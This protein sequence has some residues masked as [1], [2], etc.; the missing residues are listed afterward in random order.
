M[1]ELLADQYPEGA[2]LTIMNTFYQYP[3]RDANGNRLDDFIVIVYKD[4]ITGE[5]KY[6]IISKP[7]Y[8]FYKVKDGVPFDDTYN[9]FFIEKDKVDEVTVPYRMI[10][11]EI[12]KLTGNLDFYNENIQEMNK[13]ENKKL[14]KIPEIFASDTN[15]ED[16]YRFLFG[17]RYT[18]NITKITKAFF[19][20]EVDTRYMAGDFVQLGECPVNA[21]SFHDEAHNITITYL[22]RN[23]N[24]PLIQQFENE[25]ALGYFGESQIK[26]FVEEH[27]GGWKQNIR[28]KLKDTRYQIKFFDEEIKLLYTF[29]QDVH[30]FKPDFILSYN[31]SAF[32]IEYIIQRIYKLGYEPA[33]IICDQTWPIR[34]VKNYIDQKNIN[35]VPER[36]DFTFI[37]G[38]TTWI[39]QMI[40]YASRR[41]AKFGS[42]GSIK[43]DDIGYKEAKV[44]KLNYHHITKN[45]AMLPWLDYK[46]FVLYNIFDV[47][48]QKCIEM[49]CNDVEYIFSK[50][51]VNNTSYKKGHRQTI[52]LVNRMKKEFFKL[53]YII[54]NNANK[55]NSEPDKFL[56]AL[57]HNPLHNTDYSKKK[58]N[59][60]PIWVCDNLQDYDYKALYPSIIIEFNIAPNTQIGRI[61]IPNK[62]YLGENATMIPENK[63]SRGGEF[64]ENLVCDNIIE[65]CKRWFQLAGFKEFMEDWAEYNQKYKV[66]YSREKDQFVTTNTYYD[67]K[68]KQ[69]MTIPILTVPKTTCPFVSLSFAYQ[70]PIHIYELYEVH[71]EKLNGGNLS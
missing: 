16:Y 30:F 20:I 5:K 2:D 12:A 55:W 54:G 7:K 51:I 3:L 13:S 49:K 50:C 61:I 65:F 63:Y 69:V 44:R 23:P 6:E 14:H 10:E 58:I 25:V 43:L 70:N 46:T 18:N 53:N 68:Q 66:C 71:K 40:Q 59:G 36:G 17:V 38:Y 67:K 45:I 48:V 52:Y 1:I 27:V 8:T 64:I 56:G 62:V 15:I 19:D 39:D 9:H 32:D 37:S 26:S 57:V 33:D 29:F 4:N 42:M 21:I 47:V 31:G 11:K 34:I 28:F 60:V 41:K 35:D 24:N 22:L